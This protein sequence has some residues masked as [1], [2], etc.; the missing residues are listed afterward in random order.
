MPGNVQVTSF[1]PFQLDDFLY[2]QLKGKAEI[3]LRLN[4][5]PSRRWV[6][7][8]SNL[9]S[10][11]LK[12]LKDRGHHEFLS[13]VKIEW[14]GKRLHVS[15]PIAH[16]NLCVQEI[17]GNIEATNDLL[18]RLGRE[19]EKEWELMLTFFGKLHQ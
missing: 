12:G 7:E 6:E 10:A 15:L 13:E 17:T 1:E 4:Q 3:V 11:L 8:F 19:A 14:S 18:A 9:W 2:F 5:E 16:Y